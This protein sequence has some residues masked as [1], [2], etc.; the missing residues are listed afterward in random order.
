MALT[1]RQ[2]QAVV[3]E[4]VIRYKRAAKRERGVILDETVKLLRYNRA[5]AARALRQAAAA[6]RRRRHPQPTQASWPCA[7]VCWPGFSRRPCGR[8]GQSCAFRVVGV[9]PQPC[10]S[11]GGP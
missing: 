10:R 2:R 6:H 7:G 11:G 5:Y 8:C 1:M 9:W 3:A 4:M